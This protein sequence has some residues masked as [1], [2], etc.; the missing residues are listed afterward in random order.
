M[1]LGPLYGWS[2]LNLSPNRLILTLTFFKGIY[3]LLDIY[4]QLKGLKFAKQVY[5][6]IYKANPKP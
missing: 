1:D 4:R 5:I 2:K 3:I 6:Y